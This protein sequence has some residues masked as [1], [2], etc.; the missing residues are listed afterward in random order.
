MNKAPYPWRVV[1]SWFVLT[2]QE[3]LFL[4]GVLAILLIGLVARYLHLKSEQAEP[5]TPA[6]L[7]AAEAQR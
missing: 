3:L 4:G 6:G 5:Y 1:R 7:E 2:P